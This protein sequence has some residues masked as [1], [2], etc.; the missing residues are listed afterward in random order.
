MLDMN[1]TG[2]MMEGA[3]VYSAS[4]YRTAMCVLPLS[5]LAAIVITFLFVKHMHR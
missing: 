5:F 2:T 4:A 1:W 3:R